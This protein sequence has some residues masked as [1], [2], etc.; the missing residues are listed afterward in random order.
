MD[1]QHSEEQPP[2]IE[3]NSQFNKPTNILVEDS[4]NETV[5]AEEL[6]FWYIAKEYAMCNI[7]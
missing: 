2:A 1:S 3:N 6:L 5:S 4:D 7:I